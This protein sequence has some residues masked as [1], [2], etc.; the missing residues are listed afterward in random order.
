MPVPSGIHSIGFDG[1]GF[2]FDN[3]QPLHQV[4]R[5]GASRAIS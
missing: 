1:E 5:E 2:C 3:E 4:L